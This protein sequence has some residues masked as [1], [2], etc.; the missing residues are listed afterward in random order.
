MLPA[1]GALSKTAR[2]DSKAS[3]QHRK[4]RKPSETATIGSPGLMHFPLPSILVRLKLSDGM[5]LLVRRAGPE[6]D[7]AG[8][9]LGLEGLVPA[10]FALFRAR[11]C[12]KSNTILRLLFEPLG[13]ST[14]RSVA[15]E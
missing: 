9:R 10:A 15:T 3:T 4:C 13:P 2:S 7:A 14:K 1:A 12:L 8:D 6:V 11:H 5:A